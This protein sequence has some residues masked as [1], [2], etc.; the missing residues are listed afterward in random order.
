MS[1]KYL[2]LDQLLAYQTPVQRSAEWFELRSKYLTSSDLGTV[3]GF[4]KYKS[5]EELY[6]EKTGLSKKEFIENDA[7]KHGVKYEPEAIQMY[8]NVLG[9]SHYEIGLVPFTQF[10]DPDKMIDDS[11]DCLFLAGSVDGV[12]VSQTN[13]TNINIIEVKC[14]LFRRIKYGVIPEYYYPQVQMNIHILNVPYGDYVEYVPVNIQGN[15]RPL[16]NIVR[17]Y[18]DDNWLTAVYPVLKS[19]W[20][21]VI[22]A[23]VC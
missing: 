14:P 2:T 16:M 17:V 18:R 19:F 10:Q 8:C 20:D 13:T 11:M 15:N 6:N 23:H 3:L 7:I 12:T 9:R 4:N 5:V 1:T 22:D 21:S